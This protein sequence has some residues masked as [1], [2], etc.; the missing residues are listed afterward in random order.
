[1]FTGIDK[2]VESAGK[3]LLTLIA[4]AICLIAIAGDRWMFPKKEGADASAKF[5]VG[6]WALFILVVVFF[7]VRRQKSGEQSPVP[8]KPETK[9]CKG[10]SLQ[11]FVPQDKGT[12]SA[13]GS[14]RC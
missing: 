11:T 6:T 2:L 12:H 7:G 3:S 10:D 13:W 4:L 9:L 5:R 14:G 8:V 1:M